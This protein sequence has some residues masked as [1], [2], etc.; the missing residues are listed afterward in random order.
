MDWTTAFIIVTFAA[1]YTLRRAGQISHR[2]ARIHL[3]NGALVVD[4]RSPAEFNSD[5]LPRAINLPLQEIETQLPLRVENRNQL[6]L[7]HCH[8]GIRSSLARKKLQAM[9]YA[10]VFNLGSYGRAT[11]VLSGR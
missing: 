11:R 7:L 10:N 4:V 9:G 8:T 6:L 3:K 2:D 5:H 1:L